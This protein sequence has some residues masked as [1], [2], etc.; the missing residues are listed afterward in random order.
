MILPASGLVGRTP[1]DMDLPLDL[2]V[3]GIGLPTLIWVWPL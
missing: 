2:I 1:S 3:I